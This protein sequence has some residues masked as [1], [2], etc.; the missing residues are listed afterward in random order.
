MPNIQSQILNNPS[1]IPEFFLVSFVLQTPLIWWTA[2]QLEMARRKKIE[3]LLGMSDEGSHGWS[4]QK[5]NTLVLQFDLHLKSHHKKMAPLERYDLWQLLSI[6]TTITLKK[7]SSGIK[8]NGIWYMW[9]QSIAPAALVIIARLNWFVFLIIQK[10][11]CSVI[12]CPCCTNIH[13]L[14]DMFKS[15]DTMCVGQCAT[16]IKY[17]R[18]LCTHVCACVRESEGRWQDMGCYTELWCALIALLSLAQGEQCI[19]VTVYWLLH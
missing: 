8:R 4:G 7:N 14:N 1:Q 16:A 18:V 2:S 19:S 12:H 15:R 13:P 17:L 9:V 3:C 5:M 10:T 6:I 11:Q